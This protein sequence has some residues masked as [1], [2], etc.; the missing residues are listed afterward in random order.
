MR[1]IVIVVVFGLLAAG[2]AADFLGIKKA[3]EYIVFP[4]HPPLDSAGIPGSPD[5]IQVVTY[6]DHGATKAYGVSGAGYTC[7]GIDT[8]SDFGRS[9]IWFAGRIQDIDGAG[10]NVE[11]AVQVVAWYKK[12]P[13]FTFATMQVITDSLN[14]L[15]AI[16]DSLEHQDDW[17]STFD[18]AVDSV[19]AKANVLQVSNDAV[20]AD[21]LESAWDGSGDHSV[22][23]SLRSVNVQNGAGSAIV[24][25]STGGNGHGMSLSGHGTGK[26]INADFVDSLNATV[27]SRSSFNPAVDSVKAR[28]NVV[29]VSGDQTAADGWE[30]MLDGSGGNTLTLR[31]LRIGG[32][33]ENDTAVVIVGNNTGVSVQGGTGGDIAADIAGSIVRADSL[34][35]GAAAT[36]W[37][38]PQAD[39]MLTGSFGRYLDAPVSTVSSPSGDGAYPVTLVAVDSGSG[40]V[41]PGARLTIRNL[42]LTALLALGYT[43]VDG[44]AA[45]NLDVG[46]YVVSST[47]P[48]YLFSAHDTVTVSGAGGD[49]LAGYRFDPGTPSPPGLCRVYGF[50]Y[51]VGGQPIEGVT[52]EAKL[53]GGAVRHDEIIVSPYTVTATSDSL[54]YFFLD[55]I[56]S[57]RFTPDDATY[58]ISAAYPAGTVWKKKIHVPDIVSWRLS[59]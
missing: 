38:E 18:P 46:Q 14:V 25:A 30:T 45:F 56:P 55:L 59:W 13:T 48:G 53:I 23:L 40:G 22:T 37:N 7:A 12:L 43:G 32:S 2:T 11:L 5:S 44:S 57:S 35:D 16:N 3:G 6:A 27:A 8:T 39:H 51:A 26:D 58:Q 9:L 54:G 28:A 36:V 29:Q 50:I 15:A 33:G 47:A 10:G 1:I 21:N 4:V 20:A 52:V 41:V 34:G 42:D 31:Q 19:L 24:A 49:T 17:V